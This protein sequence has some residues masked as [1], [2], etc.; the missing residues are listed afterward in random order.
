MEGKTD[1]NNKNNG[2]TKSD[3]LKL[4]HY[5]GKYGQGRLRMSGT[6]NELT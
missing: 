5:R 1:Y 6:Y 2:K 3:S 4:E